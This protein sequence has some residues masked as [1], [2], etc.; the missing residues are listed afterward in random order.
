MSEC[1]YLTKHDYFLILLEAYFLQNCF[2]LANCAKTSYLMHWQW[3]PYA[4]HSKESNKRGYNL[5]TF[6]KLFVMPKSKN[7]KWKI[8]NNSFV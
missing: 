1:T 4:V 7:T 3:M 2:Q 6:S 8:Y 5:Q